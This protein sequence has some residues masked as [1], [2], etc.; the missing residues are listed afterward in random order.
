MSIHDSGE[1]LDV[2]GER[3]PVL[4]ICFFMFVHESLLDSL[5]GCSF[6]VDKSVFQENQLKTQNENEVL[7]SMISQYLDNSFL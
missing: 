4:S 6:Y 7:T 5:R 2:E 3:H 1:R